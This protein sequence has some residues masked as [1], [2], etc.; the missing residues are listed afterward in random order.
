MDRNNSIKREKLVINK[1]L[2]EWVFLI[3]SVIILVLLINKFLFFNV[4]VLIGL[5]IL[6][7]NINDKGLVSIVY[8]V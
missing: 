2:K 8:D 7:I 4:Y 1:F 6:I 3:V 5:M